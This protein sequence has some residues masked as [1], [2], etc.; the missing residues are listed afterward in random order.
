MSTG[1]LWCT[2]S[3]SAATRSPTSTRATP[4]GSSS[5]A[6]TSAIECGVRQSCKMRPASN[7]ASPA[8]A[9]VC[10]SVSMRSVSAARVRP[11]VIT[12]GRTR[13][14]MATYLNGARSPEHGL[15]QLGHERRREHRTGT[16]HEQTD[17]VADTPDVATA[18][19]EHAE[20]AAVGHRR[21]EQEPALQG[22]DHLVEAAEA[23]APRGAV[24]ETR[25][26]GDDRR[27][28]FRRRAIDRV[29]HRHEQAV[30]RDGDR[31]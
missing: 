30:R 21:H 5:F 6:D 8:L 28:L 22:D 27:Q 4:S 25:H 9:L 13:S 14:L 1:S 23:E 2:T 15:F 3:R 16:L 19:G 31:Q 20:P 10:T 12:N 26:A 24:A 18:T 11:P 17:L 29:R 7:A